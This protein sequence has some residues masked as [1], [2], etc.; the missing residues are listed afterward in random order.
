MPLRQKDRPQR[1]SRPLRNPPLQRTNPRETL[2]PSAMARSSLDPQGHPCARIPRVRARTPFLCP[3]L[4]S[5]L[6]SNSRLYKPSTWIPWNLSFRYIFTL[7]LYDQKGIAVN[8]TEKQ[9][10]VGRCSMNF[11]SRHFTAKLDWSSTVGS[12]VMLILMRCM[13]RHFLLL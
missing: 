5:C 10:E 1:S 2:P 3:I 6:M 13:A 9:P 7:G 11:F 12:I 4:V 8:V